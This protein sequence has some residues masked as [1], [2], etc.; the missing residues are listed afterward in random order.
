MRMTTRLWLK[1]ESKGQPKH[2]KVVHGTVRELIL[3][4]ANWLADVYMGSYIAIRIARTEADLETM[5]ASDQQDMMGELESLIA[6]NELFDGLDRDPS[7]DVSRSRVMGLFTDDPP[8]PGTL[9]HCRMMGS[10]RAFVDLG[11]TIRLLGRLGL[12]PIQLSGGWR[13][14]PLKWEDFG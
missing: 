6:Q 12:H 3:E 4:M 5:R 14:L 1:M 2:A 10:C 8:E 13:L 9:S 7:P 11:Q